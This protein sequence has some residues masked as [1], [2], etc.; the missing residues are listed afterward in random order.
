MSDSISKDIYLKMYRNLR[1]ARRFAEK[2]VEL[3]N[4][5]EIPGFLHSAIGMEAPGV[6]VGMALEEQDILIPTHRK[7]A[8]LITRGADI[9]LMMAEYMGKVTGYNKGKGGELHCSPGLEETGVMSVEAQVSVGTLPIAGG[10][11]LANKLRNE[12]RVTVVFYGD[13]GS[14][15]GAVH[16]T[17][18]MASIWNLPILFV[19]DNNKYAVTTSIEYSAKIKDLSQRAV[20]YGFDGLTVDGMDVIEVYKNAKEIVEKIRKGSGPFILET[21]S[22]RFQGHYTGEEIMNLK[23]RDKE[24]V[25]KWMERCPLKVCKER[26]LKQKTCLEKELSDIDNKVE[27]LINMAVE[28]G[29]ASKFPEPEDAIKD[30]YATVYETM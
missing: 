23:Y 21:K 22:Y 15:E 29:R 9:K 28:F 1:L 24:E 13:G 27:N 2:I 20:A 18:N 26:L 8:Q 16:E 19:C 6:G 3:G 11:A 25:K 17:M 4:L 5:G 10:I 30:M 14:N 12:K 7:P